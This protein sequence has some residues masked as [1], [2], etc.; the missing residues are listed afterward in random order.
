MASLLPSDAPSPARGRWID[1]SNPW[2]WALATC[3]LFLA[4]LPLRKTVDTDLG[5]HLRTGQWI[6][7]NHRVPTVDIYTYGAEGHEYVDSHWLYQVLV[8]L[9]YRAGGYPLLTLA[10]AAVTVFAFGL[11]FLVLSRIGAPPGFRLLF[12]LLCLLGSE[13]RFQVRPEVLTWACLAIFLYVLEERRRGGKD[14][15]FLLPWVQVFWT[16][17]EG[18][19]ILGL[20]LLGFQLASDLLHSTQRDAKLWKV[21]GL[22]AVACL[23]NP[24]FLKGALFPLTLWKSLSSPVFTANIN[25]FRPPASLTKAFLSTPDVALWA[26][27][28]FSLLLTVLFLAT[29]R[30]RRVHEWLLAASFFYLAHSHLRNIPLFLLCCL[31]LVGTCWK[32]LAGRWSGAA[33]PFLGHRALA[34]VLTL[35]LAGLCLRTLTSAYYVSE[36][37]AER[38]GI[39]LDPHRLPEGGADFLLKHGLKGR[40]LNP[41]VAGGWLEW[42]APS[43]KIY[44]DGRLEVMGERLFTEF[45]ESYQPGRLLLLLLKYQPD[46]LFFNP[47]G[48]RIAQ[49]ILDLQGIPGW[50][51]VFLDPDAVIYLRKGFAPEVPDLDFHQECRDWGVD[52]DLDRK[53]LQVLG[54]PRPSVLGGSLKDFFRTPDYPAD[55]TALGTYYAR[56]KDSHRA[57]PF[58]LRAVELDGGRHFEHFVNLGSLYQHLGRREEALLCGRKAKELAP[59]NPF[60]RSFARDLGL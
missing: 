14:L 2:T 33:R 12:F 13:I 27:W 3:F 42:R 40:I 22:C 55:M 37:R 36:G 52:P 46:I 58:F 23:V 32:D 56:T 51:P 43:S 4:L 28:I 8:H 29:F 45:V 17:V 18:L 15:L 24:Y 6:L 20:G 25:E 19:F 54:A 10:H 21:S 16:N 5:Y 60:V 57:L 53:A 59:D 7:E 39:G 31:P 50:R 26:F 11:G 41:L 35:V 44:I 38:F 1:G 49:W 30:K 47:G 9:L 48:G 34:W